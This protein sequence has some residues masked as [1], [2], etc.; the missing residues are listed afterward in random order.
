MEIQWKR[1][2]Y[3]KF[4]ARMKIRVGG[5]DT[6]DIQKGDEFE[7]D[8]TIVK[9]AG[10][11]FP[12][13]GLRG[14]IKEGWATLNPQGDG[15]VTPVR[16]ERS[17]A[18]AQSV[19]KEFSRVQ[20]GASTILTAHDHDEDVIMQVGDREAAM[21]QG[22]H[23][24]R[25]DRRVSLDVDTQEGMV[26]AKVRSATNLTADVTKD[27]SLVQEIENRS[28]E[29]GY[30]RANMGNRGKKFNV[31]GVSVSTNVGNIDPTDIQSDDASEGKVVAHVKNSKMVSEGVI[32]VKDTSGP[33]GKVVKQTT[34]EAA[35]STGDSK[36]QIARNIYSSFPEDWNFFAKP[37]DKLQRIKE[38][39]ENPVFL[40]ALYEA[41][42]KKM[43][44]ML[45]QVYTKQLS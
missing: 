3:R 21:K 25:G 34:V 8:G 20:R 28:Y 5:K 1:G 38:I 43:R 6:L 2:D 19:S 7:Y 9:Y 13:P 33:P 44:K 29:D 23:L 15:I 27:G 31:E 17:I 41:E 11:E 24:T 36:L 12:Q 18:K 16:P 37:E 32:K 26:V 10:A 30:G 40:K 39:G 4:Y 35:D 42:G 22:K 14:A 45:K